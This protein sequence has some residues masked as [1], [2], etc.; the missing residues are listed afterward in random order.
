[1]RVVS[2]FE[3]SGDGLPHVTNRPL[4][5]WHRE[6]TLLF[7]SMLHR[8]DHVIGN[9]TICPSQMSCVACASTFGRSPIGS[10]SQLVRQLGNRSMIW[11]KSQD[12][13]ANSPLRSSRVSRV[14]YFDQDQ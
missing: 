1:M 5:T 8:I 10:P 4:A 12:Q 9:Q 6:K 13:R 3:R 11:I 7:D 14:L 2:T